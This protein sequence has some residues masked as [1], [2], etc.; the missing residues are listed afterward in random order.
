MSWIRNTGENGEIC[1][2]KPRSTL[3]LFAREPSPHV[4]IIVGDKGSGKS[5]VLQGIALGMFLSELCCGTVMICLCFDTATV[6]IPIF[7]KCFGPGSGFRQFV[8]QFY[9][10]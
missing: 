1:R 5:S 6:L 2:K 10:N 8:T 4:N 3:P 7:K 9:K